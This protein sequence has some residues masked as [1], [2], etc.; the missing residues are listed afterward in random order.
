M[1][2]QELKVYAKNNKGITLLPDNG[3]WTNRM[4]IRSSSS[5]NLYIVAQHKT[6]HRWG[7]SCRGWVAHN[8]GKPNYRCKHLNAI[9]PVL[10]QI[11]RP[12][13]AAR[14]ER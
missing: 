5:G 4:E 7:C 13:L 1:A 9:V 6:N 3:Q 8:H 14:R 12:K 10:E 2:S 11:N